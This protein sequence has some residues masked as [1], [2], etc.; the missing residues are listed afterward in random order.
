MAPEYAEW[1]DGLRRRAENI[2]DVCR[3]D[4]TYCYVRG[5]VRYLIRIS[6]Y[7]SASDRILASDTIC[8]VLS[9][10]QEWLATQRLDDVRRNSANNR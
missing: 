2:K 9:Q 5:N 1:F 10:F 4:F 6:R 7:N 3:I 8:G